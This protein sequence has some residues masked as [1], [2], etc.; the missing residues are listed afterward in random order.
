MAVMDKP[1][2]EWQVQGPSDSYYDK[3]APGMIEVTSQQRSPG[4]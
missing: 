1:F 2:L 3:I 4:R